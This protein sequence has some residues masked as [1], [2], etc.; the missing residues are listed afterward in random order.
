MIL[1]FMSMNAQARSTGSLRP[2]SLPYMNEFIKISEL[3][4]SKTNTLRIELQS[5][6]HGTNQSATYI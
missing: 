6:T 3:P 1:L 4:L 2:L 5:N